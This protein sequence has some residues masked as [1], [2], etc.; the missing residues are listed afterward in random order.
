MQQFSISCIHRTLHWV[1]ATYSY[2]VP[3][4]IIQVDYIQIHSVLTSQKT[5]NK[6]ATLTHPF[7]FTPLNFLKQWVCIPFNVRTLIVLPD[8][9]LAFS[10]WDEP[11]TTSA[12]LSEEQWTLLKSELH[13]D[14]V[15]PVWC[16]SATGQLWRRGLESESEVQQIVF[17]PTACGKTIFFN[18]TG[19][20]WDRNYDS[21]LTASS[22]SRGLS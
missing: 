6:P 18:S 2:C 3:V 16:E 22:S 1:H 4:H 19:E 14:F 13:R 5:H 20:V 8:R 9:S 12:L 21:P 11:S 17:T 10:F 15:C 7:K